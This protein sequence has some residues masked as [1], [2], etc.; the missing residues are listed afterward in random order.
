MFSHVFSLEVQ[1]SYTKYAFPPR[2]SEV[3]LFSKNI[4]SVMKECPRSLWACSPYPLLFRTVMPEMVRLVMLL[5]TSAPC[6]SDPAIACSHWVNVSFCN[7]RLATLRNLNPVW[8]WHNILLKAP[9]SHESV[10][11]CHQCQPCWSLLYCWSPQLHWI[12]VHVHQAKTA[13]EFQMWRNEWDYLCNTS[14]CGIDTGD[15]DSCFHWAMIS[16]SRCF[17][18]YQRKW[19]N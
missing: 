8:P 11:K 1:L 17:Q 14:R 9:S 2:Y 13:V 4:E 10:K 18:L 6:S 19:Q 15:E 7:C 5:R 12:S 3:P 16:H